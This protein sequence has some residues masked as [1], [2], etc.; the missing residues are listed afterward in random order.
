[1]ENNEIN[2]ETINLTEI[3]DEL[4]NIKYKT[5]AEKVQQEFGVYYRTFLNNFGKDEKGNTVDDS[6]K[7][8]MIIATNSMILESLNIAINHLEYSYLLTLSVQKA[9]SDYNLSYSSNV[10]DV[11]KVTNN[12][13]ENIVNNIDLKINQEVLEIVKNLKE[14]E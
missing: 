10:T 2:D 11:L 5:L 13:I 4:E 9:N 8:E 12:F 6:I 3:I 7:K 14:Q 1:M